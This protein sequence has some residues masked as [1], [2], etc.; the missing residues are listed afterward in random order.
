[1]F[2][3]LSW[4]TLGTAVVYCRGIAAAAVRAQYHS[5]GTGSSVPRRVMVQSALQLLQKHLGSML[6]VVILV[7]S[8]WCLKAA[9]ALFLEDALAMYDHTETCSQSRMCL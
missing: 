7:P 6:A 4:W 9:L 8:S 2:I 3:F 5:Q 1:M